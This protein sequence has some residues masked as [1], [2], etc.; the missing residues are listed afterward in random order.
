M[1]TLRWFLAIQIR[2]FFSISRRPRRVGSFR[3]GV[4]GRSNSQAVL[5]LMTGVPFQSLWRTK[6]E[7]V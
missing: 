7:P 4:S 5:A 6:C 3:S 1:R 2:L